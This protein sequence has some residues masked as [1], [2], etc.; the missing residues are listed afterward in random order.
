MPVLA[1][2]T[3]LMGTTEFMLAGLLPEMAADFGVTVAQAGLLVTAFAV[4]IIVGAPVMA[5]LT[6][7]L[8][9]GLILRLA[10]VLFAVGHVVLALSS[11]FELALAARVLTA[12]AAGAFW[13]VSSVVATVAAGPANSVRALGVLTSGLTVANVVGVP[14]GALAGQLSSWRAPLWVLAGLALA[15]AV[16]IGR[17]IPLQTAQRPPSIRS[18]LRSLRSTNLWLALAASALILGGVMAAY[19]YVSPLLT[20]RAGLSASLVP[21]VLVGFGVGTVAGTATGGRLGDRWPFATTLT[22][23]AATAVVLLALAVLS[24]NAVA[25]VALVC[26][27]GLTGFTV[28]PVVGALA[29]RFGGPAPTLASAMTSSAFNV[30]VAFGS[31]AAGLALASAWG[32]VG[33]AVVGAV[34]AAAT[35]VPLGLLAIRLSRR[36]RLAPSSAGQ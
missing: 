5:L 35:L 13:A 17:F 3:F 31:W 7:R 33:P 1:V 32:T 9:R 26:L 14:L 21:L 11:S 16:V 8:S 23:A 19:T 15:A 6:L 22:A 10:L 12:M 30:G 28:N 18:E 4:G 25:A 36:P 20:D 34:I 27:L 2:G 24:S 29:L